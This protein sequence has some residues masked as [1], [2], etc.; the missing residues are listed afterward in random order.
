MIQ[1]SLFIDFLINPFLKWK[2]RIYYMFPGCKDKRKS[3]SW[4]LLETADHSTGVGF[5]EH[6]FHLDTLLFYWPQATVEFSERTD[7]ENRPCRLQLVLR[8]VQ[9]AESEWDGLTASLLAHWADTLHSLSLGDRRPL[10]QTEQA[11]RHVKEQHSSSS[12]HR[13]NKTL[14]KK[15]WTGRSLSETMLSRRRKS[16]T[17]ELLRLYSVRLQYITKANPFKVPAVV[18]YDKKIFWLLQSKKRVSCCQCQIQTPKY[19]REH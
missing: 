5:K 13:L 17:T 15:P 11:S 8:I 16:C 10:K 1:P 2:T 3:G 18:N 12:R 7:R 14:L 6:S 9:P 4:A 19:E